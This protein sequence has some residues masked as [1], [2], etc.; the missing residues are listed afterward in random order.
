MGE[1]IELT[2]EDGHKLSAYKAFPVGKPKGGVV[3]LQEIFGVNIHIKEVCDGY[4]QQGYIA[5]APALFDRV[6]PNITLNY[7]QTDIQTGLGY[8]KQIAAD[9]ALKDTDAAAKELA[10]A[11]DITVIGYCW[12]GSLAYLAACRL[13]SISKAVGYYGGMI[14]QNLGEEPK[15]PIILHFGDQ[16][17]SIPM[18]AVEE[19]KAKRPD[20]PVYIYSAGHGFNCDHRGSYDAESAKLALDRTLDFMA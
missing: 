14:P 20:I 9:D 11:G 16:D 10:D 18:S 6:D 4:A 5:I 1:L 17:A 15:V 13:S 3:I 7:E 2:A 8:M 12:G 19:V